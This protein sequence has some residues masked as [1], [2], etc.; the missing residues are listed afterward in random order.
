MTKN[1]LGTF[2]YAC[3][4]CSS[5]SDR[6]AYLDQGAYV[7]YTWFN[8]FTRFCGTQAF[9]SCTQPIG[10]FVLII[11][12]KRW[13]LTTTGCINKILN[14]NNRKNE[15]DWYVLCSQL[16]NFFSCVSFRH[17][18]CKLRLLTVV[19]RTV[20]VTITLFKTLAVIYFFLNPTGKCSVAFFHNHFPMIFD[21]EIIS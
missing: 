14:F 11:R 15:H 9:V 17:F 16:I 18:N 3:K 1:V 20:S 2:P 10:F 5:C 7:P 6:F 8:V 13:H 21:R 12:P 4:L 19:V